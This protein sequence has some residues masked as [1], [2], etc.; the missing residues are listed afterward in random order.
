MF[1]LE[2]NLPNAPG[3]YI[4]KDKNGKI[5]YVGKAKNLKKRLKNYVKNNDLDI[6]TQSM[7]SHV[8]QFDFL[9]TDS[10]T[11]A[12]ILENTL[13]KKYQPKYNIRLKDAKSHTFILLTN[14][15]FPR[16]LIA[17]QKKG[18]GKFYGPF[19]SASERDYVLDF[20]RKTFSLRTCK[21][22]PKKPCLRFHMKFCEA[23]CVGFIDEENYYKK[24]EDVKLVLSG[25]T[26]KLIKKMQNEIKKYSEENNFE[27]A[28]KTRE[29]IKA[30]EHLSEHQKMLREKKYNE[31]IINYKIKDEKVYLILFNIDRGILHNKNEF[32]FDYNQDFLEEF[33]VQYYSE[34]AVPKEVIIPEKVDSSISEFLSKKRGNKVLVTNPLK[35]EKKQLLDLVEKNV[36]LTF[37]ADFEKVEALKNKLKLEK[38]PNIIECFDISHL[39]GSAVAGSMVQFRSGKPDK[40]NYRRFKI[41][42]VDRIDDF[43]AIAEVVYRRYSRLKIE[44]KELPDLIIIDGGRGQLNAA[45]QELRK[46]DL[47]IPI[48]S[49]AKQ[50][51]EIYLPSSAMPLKLEKKDKALCF[52]QEIRDEAHRFAIKYNRLLRKKEL[53]H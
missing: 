25:H 5:I 32:V 23:P 24:I 2:K 1:S 40:T 15:K 11:E 35:G 16:V 38:F 12:L 17:R 46:L 43:A 8:Q 26:D 42:T 27:L 47:K 13:I 28:L 30:L 44:K 22:M 39:S 10:E 52:V 6:K 41:K 19:I 50:F 53:I 51:E 49:I 34:N 36:V 9:V 7:L 14:E 45:L 31:D 21:K 48:I 3:C 4:F 33:I 20:V 29:Q 18:D 37:F